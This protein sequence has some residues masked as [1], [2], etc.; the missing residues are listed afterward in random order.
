M[1]SAPPTATSCDGDEVARH[2]GAAADAHVASA[3]SCSERA[4][5]ARTCHIRKVRW[6]EGKGREEKGREEKRREGGGKGGWKIQD[7]ILPSAS[8]YV[9]KPVCFKPA[10]GSSFPQALRAA[11]QELQLSAKISL[12]LI[13]LGCCCGGFRRARGLR[14]AWPGVPSSF[15]FF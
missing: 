6:R 3:L 2:V 10:V 12:Q 8:P 11:A 4:S 1:P 15:G 9:S 14:C 5:K 7:A 13:G